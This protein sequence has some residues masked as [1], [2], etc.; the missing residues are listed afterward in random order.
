ME[1]N[2]KKCS[3]EEHPNIDAISFCQNCKIY[4]CN[5][6]LNHH[7]ALFKK[8]LI[9]NIDNNQEIFIAKCDE[10]NHYDKLNFYCKNHNILCCAACI[11][12]IKANGFGQ[13]KD[14]DVCF[15]QDIK[16]E[17]KNKLNDNMKFLEDLSN[18]L[19]NS[20]KELKSL[21]DNIDK[22]KEEIK[23]KIQN[24]FTKIRSTLN[25]REDEL[26]L[27]VDNKFNELFGNEDIIREGEKLPNK[28][29]LSLEKG[30]IN[31]ND[32][33]DNNKLSSIINIC[34]NIEDN[35][36]NINII[37]E[38]IKNYKINNDIK[39]D[40]DLEN[41]Y[42]DNFIYTI[43]SFGILY[44]SNDLDSLI[45]KNKDDLNKFSNLLSKKIKI[46][47]MKLLYRASKDGLNLNNLRDKINNKSNLIFLF[48]IGNTRIFGSFISS[49]I[50][51]QHQTY[52]KDENA[53]V[54][55]L[56]NNKIYEIL[57][58]QYAIYF[59]NGYTVLIGNNWNGNGFW[60]NSGKFNEKLLTEPKIYDFQ[61]NYELTEGKNEFNE[62][63]IFEIN[64][65]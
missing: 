1:D 14:C 30:K 53:F 28:I 56:N 55:S 40:F 4:I 60:I 8:H 37:N 62:L 61:K 29:K 58:P 23:S 41:E 2:K 35:I 9:I 10:N 45:L 38:N 24:T 13:H 39:I 51:V 6:C 36:K 64:Y 22:R 11:T 19:N 49:K 18:N 48:L 47:K 15:L 43:K 54:F 34:I 46:K 57:I 21:Y 33:N 31:E 44:A 7:Q 32:W 26:L 17:M 42:F 16:E 20:I 5:K 3:N 59:Y 25:E 65:K 63:E 50:E 12:K 27:E 52:T